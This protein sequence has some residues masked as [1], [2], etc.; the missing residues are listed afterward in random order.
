MDSYDG[1]P[2]RGRDTPEHGGWGADLRISVPAK[3]Q[4]ETGVVLSAMELQSKPVIWVPAD[5]KEIEVIVTAPDGKRCTQAG[6]RAGA[7]VQV[8]L[9]DSGSGSSDE[10]YSAGELGSNGTLIRWSDSAAPGTYRVQLSGR[11][12]AA[13]AEVVLRRCTETEFFQDLQAAAHRRQEEA[14]ASIF[15]TPE[16]RVPLDAQGRVAAILPR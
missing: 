3:G 4:A 15:A 7:T 8:Q 10:V 2:A 6:Y 5:P 14:L 9:A 11:G 13:A 16:R 1:L 12:L